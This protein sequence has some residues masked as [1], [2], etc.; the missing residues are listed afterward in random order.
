MLWNYYKQFYGNDTSLT[1]IDVCHYIVFSTF[2]NL[3][4]LKSIYFSS[5]ILE[6]TFPPAFPAFPSP[7]D[8]IRKGMLFCGQSLPNSFSNVNPHAPVTQRCSS[9]SVTVI[10]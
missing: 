3:K 1:V 8:A 6:N 4:Q 2:S 9:N 7:V 10:Q 5:P